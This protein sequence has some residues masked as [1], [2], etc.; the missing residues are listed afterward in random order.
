[1]AEGTL[2]RP[3]QGVAKMAEVSGNTGQ[4]AGTQAPLKGGVYRHPETKEEIITLDDPITGDA[5]A[6]GYVRV[7]FEWVRDVKEGDVKEVGLNSEDYANQPERKLESDTEML[8]GLRARIAAL[9]GEKDKSAEA[10]KQVTTPTTESQ[11]H[12]KEAAE[13]KTEERTT[14]NTG[15]VAHSGGVNAPAVAA[16]TTTKDKKGDK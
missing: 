7:G 8:K 10:D 11:E 3:Q 1:M 14:E 5:Q 4:V 16:P 15:D 13:Q 6:R 2:A 9:E 12:A